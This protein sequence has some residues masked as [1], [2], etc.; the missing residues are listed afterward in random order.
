MKL[1]REEKV[2]SALNY[3]VEKSL[4]KKFVLMIPPKM[5]EIFTDTD[6]NTPLIFI[7]SPGADP[8]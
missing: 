6:H 5:E 3:F 1:L 4:G 8:M 2:L 7:L